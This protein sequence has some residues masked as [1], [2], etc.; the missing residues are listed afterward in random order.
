M[1]NKKNYSIL[2]VGFVFLLSF[3][4]G[5]AAETNQD[6]TYGSLLQALKIVEGYNGDLKEGED[7]TRVEMITVM[8][9]LYPESFGSYIPPAQATFK[10]VPTT[11]W[12]FKY[13]EFAYQMGITTGKT[14]DLFGVEDQ[15]NYNQA[16]L[17]LMRYLAYDVTNVEY[18]TA[19][20][21]ISELYGLGLIVPTQGTQ[22]LLRGEVFELMVKALLMDDMKGLDAF[23][24]L[25]E[26][27]IAFAERCASVINK[28]VAISQGGLNYTVYYA[29]GDVY[30]GGFDGEMKQG[31]GIL[32]LLN[33]DYYI[34][35]FKDDLLQGYGIFVWAEG[36]FYE[37][38]WSKDMF[39]GKG[40]YTYPNGT[41]QSGDWVDNVLKTITVELTPEELEKGL[42]QKIES[43]TI[44]LLDDQG[45]PLKGVPLTVES[46]LDG[47]S[48]YVVTDAKGEISIPVHTDFTLLS[49]VL[50]E[51]S[52]YRFEV[53]LTNYM[54]T[55][56]GQYREGIAFTLI[57]K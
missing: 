19:A 23:I 3:S 51:N 14:S 32:R 11:H 20:D 2:L 47:V 45:E 31:N 35:Q 43:Y 46:Q 6:E 5:F 55:S 30:T 49:L 40:I 1:F 41:Y 34:G 57:R 27:Q 29:V 26:D 17:F 16:S 8:S 36:D 13:V 39:N 10:D 18:K 22:S 9:R 15:V 42:V 52:A 50:A 12:G 54:V 25:E 38:Y 4:A 21:Q 48:H 56:V 28:P 33:G 7:I 37:G 44:K 24:P 53:T